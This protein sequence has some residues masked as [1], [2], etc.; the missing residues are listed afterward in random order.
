MAS[1]P[2]VRRAPRYEPAGGGLADTKRRRKGDSHREQG[3]ERFGRKC[4]G[5]PPGSGVRSHVIG[6]TGVPPTEQR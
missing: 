5:V 1:F 4:P 2:P 3:K 6:H